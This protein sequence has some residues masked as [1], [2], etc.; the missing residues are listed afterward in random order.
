MDK[1]ELKKLEELLWEYKLKYATELNK[2]RIT[3][4]DRSINIINH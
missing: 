3:F 4:S 2:K 1:E